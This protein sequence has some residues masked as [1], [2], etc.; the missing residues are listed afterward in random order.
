MRALLPILFTGFAIIEVEERI[1]LH[2][3]A[4]PGVSQAIPF[5]SERFKT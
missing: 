2:S 3:Q 4:E 5:H 1:E